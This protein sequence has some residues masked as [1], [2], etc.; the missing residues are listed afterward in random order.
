MQAL[1]RF[2]RLVPVVAVVALAIFVASCTG[3]KK[4]GCPNKLQVSSLLK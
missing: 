2:R 3:S 4:Y 1:V